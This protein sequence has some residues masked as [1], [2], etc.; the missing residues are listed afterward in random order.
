MKKILLLI[1]V[2]N[3]CKFAGSQNIYEFSTDAAGN[4]TKRTTTP[5]SV[6][7]TAAPSNVV[8]SGTIVTFTATA[9]NPGTA[10]TYQWK[11]NGNNAGSNSTTF[12]CDSLSTGDTIV[13]K[14]T[15]NLSCTLN[16]PAYSNE[17]VMDVIEYPVADAGT[18][19][20]YTGTPISIG[21][22][23]NGPGTISWLP[24]TG[25]N[26]DTIAEPLASPATT[27]TYTLTIDN[28][29]CTSTDTITVTFGGVHISGTTM[30]VGRAYAGSPAPNPPTYNSRIYNINKE[31]VILKN[32]SG[33]E[34]ARDT[35]DAGGMFSF[36]SILNGNYTL[37]Y[38]K[39]TADT[40]QWCDDVNA[41]D[42]SYVRYLIGSDTTTDPSKNFSRIYK[43]AA[44]VNNSGI[45]DA[46]DV[47]K[48]QAKIG[49]PYD[50]TKN[51]PKG[52]WVNLDTT[53][54]VYGTN[55]NVTLPVI[56]YGDYNASSSKYRDS[57]NTW[58]QAK[59]LPDENII[60]VS[61]ES[62][63]I[64]NSGLLEIPLRI[65]SPMNDFST[66]G[67]ELYYPK[68]N[69]VLVSASM[70]NTSDSNGVFKINPSL[71]EIIDQNDDLLV[72]DDNGTI[73]VVFA[74]T[75]HFDVTENDIMIYLGFRPLN[76]LQ[77]GALDFKLFGTGLIA[78]Q[79]GE[80]L[81]DNTFLI[82]PQIYIQGNSS[83][84]GFEFT[85][86]PNP[87]KG[88]ATLTYN[89]P[90]DGAV[91][92]NVYNAIGVLVSELVNEKQVSGKHTVLFSKSN[93]Q[94]GIYTFR[95]EY[96]SEQNS[97]CAVLKMIH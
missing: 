75:N 20:T 82:I 48:I 9:I 21:S 35:S 45:I 69:F 59:S 57:A 58:S 87:F 77:Q 13:C 88:D 94:S 53:V 22:S 38:D 1:I 6:A 95:L 18:D 4:R 78:N 89:I 61:D 8:C 46:L 74:T 7:I 96:I 79:Y 83:E 54:T 16:N 81:K 10:A 30:Y 70:P 19:T 34:I 32:Q 73:R 86:Y 80:E 24:D 55:I 26:N 39:Y 29:G 31:I 12:S 56:S 93:L 17:I 76:M 90:E 49:S 40:M 44:D 85:G 15:S 62:M 91:K 66:L 36:S 64:N 25:L 27:K 84:A 52:N 41:L 28:K 11:I 71:Q 68:E 51:F 50:P 3:V 67:L 23:L 14:L 5:M 97:N 65:S 2:L 37:S 47:S 72:T 43:K 63:I 33:V 92:L 42:V 60:Y